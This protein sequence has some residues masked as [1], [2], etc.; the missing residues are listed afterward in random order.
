MSTNL[1]EKYADQIPQDMTVTWLTR[2]V[3][4]LPSR[5]PGF[6]SLPVRA[7]FVVEEVALGQVCLRVIWFSLSLSF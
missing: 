7:G 3:A 6:S 4:V 5:R 1:S 2:L